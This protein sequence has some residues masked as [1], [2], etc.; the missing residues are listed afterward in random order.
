MKKYIPIFTVLLIAPSV[1]FASWW[2]P[3][4]WGSQSTS[5]SDLSAKIVALEQMISKK[6]ADI[7]TLN[8]TIVTLSATTSIYVGGT[9]TVVKYL[10]CP[11][12]SAPT[13]IPRSTE[14]SNTSVQLAPTPKSSATIS[15]DYSSPKSGTVS[16]YTNLPVLIFDVNPSGNNF[17]PKALVANISSSGAGSVGTAYLYQGITTSNSNSRP[18]ATAVVS[19]GVANFSYISNIGTSPI[20]KGISN[21]FTVTVD[22][23]GLTTTIGNMETVSA[24]VSSLLLFDSDGDTINASGSAQGEVITIKSNLQTTNLPSVTPASSQ[25]GWW[26]DVNH[27]GKLVYYGD[28]AMAMPSY[29][30][31]SNGG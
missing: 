22:V 13:T 26:C 19:N 11:N 27:N 30:D 3:L 12:A 8:A 18:I 23:S 17:Y 14:V 4:S 5:Q 21:V 31:C 15:L 16:T 24:S 28:S 29:M 6:D 9:K 20:N 10:P 7:A 2:N 25:S 1:A